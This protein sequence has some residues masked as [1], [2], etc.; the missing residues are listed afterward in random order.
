MQCKICYLD[1][2]KLA[3][4]M[5]CQNLRYMGA[6]VQCVSWWFMSICNNSMHLRRILCI[7]LYRSL[8]ILYTYSVRTRTTLYSST[9]IICSCYN[10][11]MK[12][13]IN[14]CVEKIKLNEVKFRAYAFFDR[15]FVMR[16][17][18]CLFLCGVN[19]IVIFM[20]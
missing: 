6:S 1:M 17:C 5:S 13:A 10:I 19:F 11:D 8:S 7:W 16:M 4:W 3:N 2:L 14:A 20:T 15:V 18:M 12:K 9:Y